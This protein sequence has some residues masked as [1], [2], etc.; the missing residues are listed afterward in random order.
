MRQQKLKE[1]KANL[2]EGKD[3]RLV[4]PDS[5]VEVSSVDVKAP[6]KE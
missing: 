2:P 5:N 4:S 6:P 1:H 3:I